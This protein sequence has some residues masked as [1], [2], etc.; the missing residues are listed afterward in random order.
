MQYCP[1]QAKMLLWSIRPLRPELIRVCRRTAHR[2]LVINAAGDSLPLLPARPALTFPVAER[3]RPSAST[4]LYSS[5][6]EAH[7]CVCH[8]LADSP[9]IHSYNSWTTESRS[10]F[11]R[12]SVRSPNHNTAVLHQWVDLSKRFFRN[13]CKPDSCLYHLLPPP[14]DLAVTS[15]LRKPTVYPRPSLRTKRYCLAVSY[16]LLN[17]Q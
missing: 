16:A 2:R 12:V 4:Q 5:M 13:I 14:R 6:T 11:S 9:Y 17:F 10:R 3:H 8:Q 15:R 7:V 1:V